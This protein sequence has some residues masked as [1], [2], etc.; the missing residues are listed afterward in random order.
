MVVCKIYRRLTASKKEGM[1]RPRIPATIFFSH[2]YLL[3]TT[4]AAL[5]AALR[6][7]QGADVLALA[8]LLSL[9]SVCRMSRPTS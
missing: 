9:P 1:Q 8:L 7:M 2:I 3:N 6:S 4:H 5:P